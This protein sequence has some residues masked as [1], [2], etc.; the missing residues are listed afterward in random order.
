MASPASPSP[1]LLGLLDS[2]DEPAVLL[3]P[4]YHILAANVAYRRV[5]GEVGR[6][7]KCFQV[8]HGYTVP[9]DQAGESCPLKGSL[10]TGQAQRVLHLHQTPR[11]E[12]HVDV[13]TRP[14]PGADGHVRY[15]LETMRQSKV[16]SA[17][18]SA[19]KLVGRSSAFNHMLGLVQRV[20]P[21]EAAVLLLGETG[22][23]KE[24]VAQALH[25]LSPRHTGPFVAVECAGL[26]DTLFESELFGHERGAFTGATSLKV[27]LV[28]AARGGTLFLDELGDIPLGMQV[29]LLRLLET[30]TFRRVGG[31]EPQKADF[32]LVCATHRDLEALVRAG[33]FREDLYYRISVFPIHLPTLRERREDLSLLA[34]ALLARIPSARD[35]RLGRD[36]LAML[37]DYP[38]PG[39][40]RELRNLL[41]RASLLADDREIEARHLALGPH[42]TRQENL[43]PESGEIIPL[44]DLEGRY[45][46]QV[47][48]RYRGERRELARLLG[49][50][51]RTLYRKLEG[52]REGR[53]H[54]QD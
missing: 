42:Q 30:G 50:S 36:A 39:N 17:R 34:E 53:D 8:S 54:G 9:C 28:E 6:G 38:F 51:E 44:D 41:E 2:H 11:G 21:S 7:H 15:V 37:R 32:R 4:D 3:D 13:E 31:I 18:P 49:V 43:C 16:A 10:E 22:T 5:Y 12:E 48:A 52:L 19:E 47:S 35:K 14:I 24:L 27:G 29:K 25:E 33:E 40:I 1:E 20:A 26:T 46:R 45:L 23:G